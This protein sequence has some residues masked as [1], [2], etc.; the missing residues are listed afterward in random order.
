MADFLSIFEGAIGSL[1]KN[2]PENRRKI[3]K[4]GT[5]AVVCQLDKIKPNITNELYQSQL[6]KLETA[7]RQCELKYTKDAPSSVTLLFDIDPEKHVVFSGYGPNFSDSNQTT[8]A[9]KRSAYFVELTLPSDISSDFINNMEDIFLERW[10]PRYGL[11]RARWIW[12]T[13]CYGFIIRNWF[14]H[15]LLIAERVMKLKSGSS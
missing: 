10:V 2:T 14:E 4:T 7:I 5:E 13:Q 6:F 12:H 8:K 11:R 15:I 3:Y 9:M 1:A